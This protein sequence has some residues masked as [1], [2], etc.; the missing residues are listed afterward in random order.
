MRFIVNPYNFSNNN[1][2]RLHP[3]INTM[4]TIRTNQHLS[5]KHCVCHTHKTFFYKFELNIELFK[6]NEL[7]QK[8]TFHFFLFTRNLKCMLYIYVSRKNQIL[9]LLKIFHHLSI[10]I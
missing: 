7:T 9:G 6:N 5:L 2:I 3:A 1:K 8:K 4:L 10:Y